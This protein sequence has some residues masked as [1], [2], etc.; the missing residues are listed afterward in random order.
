MKGV[1]E[2]FTIARWDLFEVII[3]RCEGFWDFR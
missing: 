1:E 3:I 2:V